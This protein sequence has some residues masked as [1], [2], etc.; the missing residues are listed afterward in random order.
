M[1]NEIIKTLQTKGPT[2]QTFEK[3]SYL[4]HQDDSIHFVYFVEQGQIELTRFQ[5]DGTAL[6]LQ[7]AGSGDIIAEASVYSESYHCDAIA[8]IFS[9]VFFV[10]KSTFLGLIETESLC[11][12]WSNHLAREMQSARY[13]AELLSRKTVSER[14]SSW[15]DWPGN[16]LP[17]KGEWKGLAQQIGVSPE[18]LYREMAKRKKLR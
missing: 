4:F 16:K 15:L 10:P 3:G 17:E 1:F 6:V 12:A 14:L 7:R 18:A 5:P 2:R 9:Q 13:R 11:R 8:S